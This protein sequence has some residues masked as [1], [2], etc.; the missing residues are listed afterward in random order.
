MNR[1]EWFFSSFR[2]EIFWILKVSMYPYALISKVMSSK[3]ECLSSCTKISK[4]NFQVLFSVLFSWKVFCYVQAKI[5]LGFI[6]ANDTFL[7][8]M[9]GKNS[10]VSSHLVNEKAKHS[11]RKLFNHIYKYH[12]WKL[13]AIKPYIKF[14]VVYHIM[15]LEKTT[16]NP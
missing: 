8:W 3:N 4:K 14:R 5:S 16:V 9:C 15:Q 7:N 12:I 2:V 11:V 13:D 6:S 10:W 1:L